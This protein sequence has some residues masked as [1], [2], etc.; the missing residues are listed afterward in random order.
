MFKI[1]IILK[2]KKKCSPSNLYTQIIC[3]NYFCIRTL[4]SKNEMYTLLLA[5]SETEQRI[6]R[7]FKCVFCWCGV[8]G[9][10]LTMIERRRKVAWVL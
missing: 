10:D 7:F 1:R 9:Q 2:D 3:I 8:I 6:F 4:I 5:I